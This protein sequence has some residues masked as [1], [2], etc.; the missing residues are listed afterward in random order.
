MPDKAKVAAIDGLNQLFK[1][2][3]DGRS[4]EVIVMPGARNIIDS[5]SPPLYD[6]RGNIDGKV[7][8]GRHGSIPRYIKNSVLPLIGWER[9]KGIGIVDAALRRAH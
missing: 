9:D 2:R 8:H 1:V 3:R 5:S 7:T 4:T 6:M